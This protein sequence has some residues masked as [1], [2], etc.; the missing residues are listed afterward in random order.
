MDFLV[1]ELFG[2]GLHHLE[3]VVARQS[4]NIVGAGDAHLVLG[5]GVPRL[6]FGER[7][8]PVE[9]VGAG[10]IAIHAADPEF[11][12]VEPQRCARPM[13]RRSADRFDDPGRHIGEIPGDAP[14]ARGRAHIRP[15][16]LREAFPLIVDEIL[17]L[18]ARAGLEDH[19]LD[20]FLGEFVAERSAAG[21]GAH[22]YNNTIVIQIEF[23]HVMSSQLMFCPTSSDFRQPVDVVETA[24]D[25]AAGVGGRSPRSRTSATGSSWL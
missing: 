1:A 12:L 20:A 5:L 23:C 2:A 18:G 25:V 24:L 4:R 8:R 10:Q 9:Q 21:A 3:I 16:Q 7:D 22:D 11:V 19:D 13:H 17:Q 6:H 15:C 14:V